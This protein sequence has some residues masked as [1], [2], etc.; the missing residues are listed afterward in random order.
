MALSAVLGTVFMLA[1]GYIS[2]YGLSFT[3]LV[4]AARFASVMAVMN[5]II[6]KPV[7]SRPTHI[8]EEKHSAAAQM[9]FGQLI[10][11][12]KD[13]VISVC[14]VCFCAMACSTLAGSTFN[15]ILAYD[16]GYT[17][18]T[19]SQLGFVMGLFAAAVTLV[20]NFKLKGKM[21]ASFT[22]MT[23]ASGMLVSICIFTA[24]AYGGFFLRGI[25]VLAIYRCFT[26]LLTPAYQGLMS[27]IDENN[28]GKLMSLVTLMESMGMLVGN[29]LSPKFA[30]INKFAP[31]LYFIPLVI[32]LFAGGCVCR[33][34]F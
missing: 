23:G 13:K 27:E 28:R 20:Y 32:L 26:T 22:L 7:R 9:S 34:N 17:S 4:Q 25:C 6:P 8:G 15:S 12:Y 11:R 19:I 5:I 30:L 24:M 3:F 14:V 1:G 18:K 29:F 2:E 10:S 16:Y 31:Y 33:K 21:T